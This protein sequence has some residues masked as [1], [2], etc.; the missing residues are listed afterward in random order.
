[1]GRRSD[2]RYMEEALA[3]A[4]RGRER[5]Y[6]NPMVGAVIV[7][8]GRIIGRGYHRRAG[9]DHAE[10]AAIKD[11]GKACR[12]AA[13]YVTLEPC[14][15]YGRTPPCTLAIIESGI[16]SV[17]AAMEDP[18]PLNSGRGIRKLSS[19]G[20]SVSTGLCSADAKK[21]NRKY[22]KFIT[23][24][25]PYVTLKL[26]QSLDGKIAA[27]DGSSRWISSKTSREYVRRIRP[28]FDAIMVG[29][30]TLRLD[31]PLLMDE[32]RKE[33]GPTRV[34]VDSRLRLRARSK[35]IKTA[36]LSPVIIGTTD[37]APPGRL[38][39]VGVMDG[40]DLIVTRNKRGRVPLKV[41]L[42][43]LARRG[44]VNMLVEG[45]GELAGSL[46]DG[47][48]VDEVMFFISPRIMGGDRVSVKGAGAADIS[49]AVDLKDVSISMSGDDVFVRGRICSPV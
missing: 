35:L 31:D 46:M 10:V 34:V 43:E 24:G 39:S 7:K 19:R 15:H 2:R 23:R 22:I 47:G 11:A 27:R 1:M 45:G 25:L 48:L 21:L 14:D 17:T 28:G 13:M 18:N 9:A 37:L 42:S 41:F 26:A 4:A 49:K 44:I 3:L 5:T 38:K 29:A 32:A 12:G 20:I 36:H 33:P 8:G 16:K 40:V 30:N 6:P